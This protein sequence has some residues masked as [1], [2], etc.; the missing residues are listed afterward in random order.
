MTSNVESR[1]TLIPPCSPMPHSAVRVPVR[2]ADSNQSTT[3]ATTPSGVAWI[4][5]MKITK[6][7][8]LV[9]NLLMC[10][11]DKLTI[12]SSLTKTLCF[13]SNKCFLCQ[14]IK[15]I[16]RISDYLCKG[17][18]LFCHYSVLFSLL[19][20]SLYTSRFS[21]ILLFGIKTVYI[22]NAWFHLNH[23][24]YLPSQQC[25]PECI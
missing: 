19:L 5:T 13:I 18:C 22:I 25:L 21:M 2:W 3:T 24:Q 11:V 9:P 4:T 23:S 7:T 1:S 15:I 14:C 10:I 6:S 20:A 8:V 12:N 17:S 16:H